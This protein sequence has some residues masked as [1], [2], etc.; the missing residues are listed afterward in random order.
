MGTAQAIF[1]K[2][3]RGRANGSDVTRNH[4]TGS[5]VAT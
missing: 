4:M 3:E 5:D 2:V 1:A